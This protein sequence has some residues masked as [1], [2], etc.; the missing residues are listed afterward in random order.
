MTTAITRSFHLIYDNTHNDGSCVLCPLLI[1]Y[2]KICSPNSCSRYM[3]RT[4]SGLKTRSLFGSS[5]IIRPFSIDLMST[6]VCISRAD[7]SSTSVRKY[8]YGIRFYIDI[9]VLGNWINFQYKEIFVTNIYKDCNLDQGRWNVDIGKSSVS[10][11]TKS[12]QGRK[13]K[14]VVKTIYFH[15]ISWRKT[16]PCY[17]RYCAT[18]NTK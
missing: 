11:D 14:Q 17:A 15:F 6:I 13:P 16:P 3:Q 9:F 1:V 2:K 12:R 4:S 18:L 10:N 5:S 7:N 8:L